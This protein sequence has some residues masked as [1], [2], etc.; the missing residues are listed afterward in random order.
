MLLAPCVDTRLCTFLKHMSTHT[1]QHM[2]VRRHAREAEL[3]S[4]ASDFERAADDLR[5][6]LRSAREDAAAAVERARAAERA[7]MHEPHQ[8]F[9]LAADA[10]ISVEDAASTHVK[11]LPQVPE[12]THGV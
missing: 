10:G 9:E 7:A 2:S 6:E 1:S 3:S 12:Y 4:A 8:L 11:S 5:R